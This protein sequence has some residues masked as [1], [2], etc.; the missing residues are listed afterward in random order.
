MVRQC[1][2][3]STYYTSLTMKYG[4]TTHIDYLLPYKSNWICLFSKPPQNISGKALLRLKWIDH[5]TMN[6]NTSLTCRH[7]DIP[8]STF[9]YWLNRFDPE[10]LT[11]L[12]NISRRPHNVRKSTVSD[13]LTIEVIDIRTTFR[14]WGKVKIQK[15]LE[16]RSKH[17]GQSR[18]QKIINEAGLKRIK[19]KMRR[20]LKRN[21]RHMYA[22]PKEVLSQPGG[23]VYLDVKHLTLPGGLKAYQF[24]AVDHATRISKAK[25]YPNITSS[26][27][28]KFL[29]YL[30]TNFPFRTITYIGSDNGSEFLGDLERY[31]E[32][33]KIIHVF[34]SPRS[35]KQNPYVERMIR[36]IIDEV[37]YYN[38]L[39]ITR[40]RQQ[41]VLDNYLFAYNN[42]RPHHSLNMNTP[43]QEYVRLTKHFVSHV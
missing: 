25:Y 20:R 15:I 26:S 41:E 39:E 7:F 10:D 3:I 22:V 4:T 27:G 23:L 31:L 37:Y 42:I 30:Q 8:R 5:F 21:R 35:P 28:V 18:I 24:T 14:G 36:T 1:G 40:E 33:E 6:S 32:K 13:N 43:K 2:N 11:T 9:Y 34:S 16:N 19:G 12:E 17:V 38:G 29:K